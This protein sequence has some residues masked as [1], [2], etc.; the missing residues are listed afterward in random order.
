MK[1]ICTAG[2]VDHGKSTLVEAL[3][4][5]HPDRLIEEREREMTIDLGFAWLELPGVGHVGIVDVPGHR[6]FVGNMLAG[7][8]S[9]DAALLVVAADE[10]IM[11]QTYEHVAILDLLEIESGVVALTKTDLAESEEWVHLISGDVSGALAGTKMEGAVIVPVVAQ[12][13]EGINQLRASLTGCLASRPPRANIGRPRLSIDR[14][15]T[16]AGF[17]TVVTGTLVDGSLNVGE[18]VSILPSGQ[19]ARIRGMQAYQ[20]KI[21]TAIAGSRV[22]INLTGVETSELRRGEVVA[23]PGTMRSTSRIDVHF[24]H[25][26]EK[27]GTRSLRHNAEV[28]LFLGAAEVMAR[29]RLL[30]HQELSPGHMGWLQLELREPVV[31]AKGDHFIV[32]RPSPPVTIGGGMVV[33]AHPQ[34]RHRL[35]D[36]QVLSRLETSARGTP[37]EILLQSLDAIGP[38]E[39]HIGLER[40]GLDQK[41][42][43]EAVEELAASGELVVL[44]SGKQSHGPEEID[45]VVSR[46]GWILFVQQANGQVQEYHTAHPLRAGMPREE[47]KSRLGLASKVF[48]GFVGLASEQDILVEEGPTVRLPSHQVEFTPSQQTRVDELLEYFRRSVYNTPSRKDA[49]AKVGAEILAVLLEREVIVAVSP[50]VIF[51]GDTYA[52]MLSTIR[53]QLRLRGTITVAEVR[54]LFNTSR[55]YA[56]AILEHMD[57]IGITVRRGDKRVLS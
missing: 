33:D 5:T 14:V 19:R 34:Q 56:L 40:A 47:L 25:L 37:A 26:H 22:A 6:D 54:D 31:A 8:G 23:K 13:G 57:L 38:A 11:P 29:V 21:A 24:R 36:G 28:K 32:R 17:G 10:G 18:D 15:F 46:A 55:K 51:L 35:Q 12:T 4:G 20:T 42:S 53:E 7:V 49:L 9:V 16:M 44:D 39:L 43:Q 3:T 30:S 41:S 45:L 2:H 27:H 48:N 52:T 1:V 50:E